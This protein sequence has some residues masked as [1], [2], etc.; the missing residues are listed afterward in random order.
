MEGSNCK[1]GL[2]P[3]NTT[4]R[5]GTRK[6]AARERV[7]QHDVSA[8]DQFCVRLSGTCEL[9]ASPQIAQQSGQA[10]QRIRIGYVAQRTLRVFVYL[11]EHSVDTD[12]SRSARQRRDEL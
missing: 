12:S 3:T 9:I 4:T 2:R 7:G 11:H 6:R 5:L 1:L 8:A 10:I